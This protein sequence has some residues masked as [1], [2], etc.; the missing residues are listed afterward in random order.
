MKLLLIKL[1][2]FTNRL[3]HHVLLQSYLVR[4]LRP[5]IA[6]MFTIK[7]QNDKKN[8]TL[9]VPDSIRKK[10]IKQVNKAIFGYSDVGNNF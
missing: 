2:G 6:S 9:Q 7:L 8:P 10:Y 3:R 5:G 1:R 4:E